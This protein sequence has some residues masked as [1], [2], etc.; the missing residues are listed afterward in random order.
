[1]KRKIW[2]SFSYLVLLKSQIYK[3]DPRP[4]MPRVM[5][6]SAMGSNRKY[7]PSHTWKHTQT[8]CVH[9][10]RAPCSVSR[11]FIFTPRPQYIRIWQTT[12]ILVMGIPLIWAPCW[13]KNGAGSGISLVYLWLKC[14]HMVFVQFKFPS[15]L[16]QLAVPKMHCLYANA[17]VQPSVQTST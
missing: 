17:S 3:G 13:D 1:M 5:L 9:D 4:C 14:S 7:C 16:A 8:K 6:L 15:N 2:T 12:V 11:M 10:V